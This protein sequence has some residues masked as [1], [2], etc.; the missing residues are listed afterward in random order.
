MDNTFIR[1]LMAAGLAILTAAV[2]VGDAAAALNLPV[3]TVN[4][5]SYYYHVVQPKET[6]YSLSRQ[7]GVE[8]ADIVK[9]NPSVIDG[10]RTKETLYFPVDAFG[11]PE[12]PAS[13]PTST[14]PQASKAVTSHLVKKGE[15]AYGISHRY[16]CTVDELMA[17][18]PHIRDGVKAG[19]IITI[20][21]TCDATQVQVE[22]TYPDELVTPPSHDE[23]ATAPERVPWTEL[24]PATPATADSDQADP[25]EDDAMVNIAV[26]LPFQ[27]NRERP[28][29]QAMH[30]TDFYKGLLMAVDTMRT[31][32]APIHVYA[33]DTCDN[34]DSV[35]SI[36]ANR[37]EMAEMDMIIAPDDTAHIEMIAQHADTVAATVINMFA[38][39]DNSHLRH[40]S[41]FQGN[42]PHEMMYAKAIDSFIK[43]FD[44]YTPVILNQSDDPKGCDK[45]IFVN[46]LT[47][48]LDH[49]SIP[50]R[51][52]DYTGTLSDSD[53]AWMAP[54]VRY[55][56]IPTS[57]SRSVLNAIL[58]A[59]AEKRSGIDAPD[60]LRLFGFPEWIILRGDLQKKLHEMNTTIYSRFV[61][62]ADSYRTRNLENRFQQWYGT[63]MIPTAPMQGTLGYDTG[64]W[65]ILTAL[66]K[67][68]GHKGLQSGFEPVPVGDGE[69]GWINNSLY[70]IHFL[71]TGT[72]ERTSL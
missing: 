3:K 6:I 47:S 53:I 41:V 42:I 26:M 56:V 30:Y 10:I 62:D 43:L 33:Y 52:V 38:V 37:P 23:A 16:G 57:S 32:G 7:L 65:A 48:R 34:A 51:T 35:A 45:T 67:D 11:A 63:A 20:P 17:A 40:S 12:S 49:D 39:R 15:T 59:L 69:Q 5:R 18:N 64:M 71:P 31:C 68:S 21:A 54:G 46:A 61:M 8:R 29:K 72:I 13:E 19:E 66:G 44:G 14:A 55:V 60:E 28:N 1:R 2:C 27:L 36:L 50:Y 4:G 25:D 9:Y 22:E 58:P 70:F 24:T